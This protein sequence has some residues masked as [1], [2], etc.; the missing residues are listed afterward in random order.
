MNYSRLVGSP[1][2]QGSGNPP[3][4]KTENEQSTAGR[5]KKEEEV[6]T[7]LTNPESHAMVSAQSS[8][9]ARQCKA[10]PQASSISPAVS[11]FKHYPEF[12]PLLT[13][14][15][16]YQPEQRGWQNFGLKT[17]SWV[18][19]PSDSVSMPCMKETATIIC[20]EVSGFLCLTQLTGKDRKA[21]EYFQQRVSSL[22]SKGYPYMESLEVALLFPLVQ[23]MYYA[24]YASCLG[25]TQQRKIK[26]CLLD[27]LQH[28]WDK[29][30]LGPCNLDRLI[31]QP[32]HLL[33]EETDT[34]P[35][36]PSGQSEE[37]QRLV[38][39]YEAVAG[40]VNDTIQK[41]NTAIENLNQQ[42]FSKMVP[43]FT[44]LSLKALN[45][46]HHLP[47]VP[48]GLTR[49]ICEH[50]DGGDMSCAYV[51]VHDLLHDH[52]DIHSCLLRVS[53]DKLL[54]Y[55][56][57]E[58]LYGFS[59]FVPVEILHAV[60]LI[61]F[62]HSHERGHSLLKLN[63]LTKALEVAQKV[64]LNFCN[65]GFSDMPEH[66]KAVSETKNLPLAAVLISLVTESLLQ[67]SRNKSEVR[68][69]VILKD[70]RKAYK[71][72]DDRVAAC[73]N[74]EKTSAAFR[75]LKDSLWRIHPP[76]GKIR[77]YYSGGYL[78]LVEDKNTT[79]FFKQPAYSWYFINPEFDDVWRK[80]SKEL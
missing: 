9:R 6:S 63:N 37:K 78:F 46:F 77:D 43:V 68:L 24:Q 49:E 54:A 36:G 19:A 52:Y 31:H 75:L 39:M 26:L 56:V 28:R 64:T 58:T 50:H 70:F 59:P 62:Q 1:V 48:V 14:E 73:L 25:Q 72:L 13:G 66:Y 57:T 76:S 79:L 15:D 29:L 38:H 80:V 53:N 17:D 60:E 33:Y 41:D 20:Q 23:G 67:A 10:G 2:A 32:W 51:P 5:I 12:S 40:L 27:Q 21:L 30:N 47:I 69:D 16:F 4:A 55:W 3:C 44:P 71:K 74:L 7:A 65:G 22:A 45:M 35:T 34:D 18:S 61:I 42:H 11:G 8:V